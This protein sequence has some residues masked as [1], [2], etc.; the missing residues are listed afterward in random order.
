MTA[1]SWSVFGQ[2]NVCCVD[3][4]RMSNCNYATA[5]GNYTELVGKSVAKAIEFFEDALGISRKNVT[6]AGHSLGAQVAGY[7]G[8]NLTPKHKRTFGDF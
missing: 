5:A 3:W 4:S 2:S 6:I 7:A 1:R 8:A